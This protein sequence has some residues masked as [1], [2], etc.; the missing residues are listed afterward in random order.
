MATHAAVSRSRVG[1][2]AEERP[3]EAKR[4]FPLAEKRGSPLAKC[5]RRRLEDGRGPRRRPERD[6]RTRVGVRR[7]ENRP[8]HEHSHGSPGSQFRGRAATVPIVARKD[9]LFDRVGYA[10]P[11]CALLFADQVWSLLH[12]QHASHRWSLPRRL[13]RLVSLPPAVSLVVWK[14]SPRWA[15]AS[16]VGA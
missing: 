8:W 2:C 6:G 11:A 15:R 3:L 10:S 7:P 1:V 4:G 12:V 5:L 9:T 16:P 13:V 14:P